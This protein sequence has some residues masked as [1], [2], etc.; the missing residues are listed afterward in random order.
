[1]IA[2][3]CIG[4]RTVTLSALHTL[5][6]VRPPTR[7]RPASR[8]IRGVAGDIFLSGAGTTPRPTRVQT[9]P[10]PELTVRA[11]SSAHNPRFVDRNLS[12]MRAKRFDLTYGLAVSFLAPAADERGRSEIDHASPSR[13]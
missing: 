9:K 2:G 1:M 5:N 12:L 13:Q 3:G 11:R 4:V 10:R 8:W 6:T 7:A